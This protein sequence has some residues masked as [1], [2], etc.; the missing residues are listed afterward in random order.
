[1]PLNFKVHFRRPGR[2]WWA[3]P[4]RTP[5]P[6]NGAEGAG[7]LRPPRPCRDCGGRW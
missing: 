6:A 4:R 7:C 2:W 1:M 3:R 5:H